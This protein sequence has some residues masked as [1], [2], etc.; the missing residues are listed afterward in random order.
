MQPTSSA[1]AAEGP[2]DGH[3]EPLEAL[4]RRYGLQPPAESRLAVLLSLLSTDTL[5]PTAVRD[6]AQAVD[7]HLAD[8]LVALELPEVRTARTIA[9]LGAGAGIPGLPLAIALPGAD[10]SLVESNARKA[11]FITRAV[12]ACGLANAHV[13]HSR[14]E[15]WTA[16]LDHFELVTARA[17][18]PPAVVA[19]YAAP[20]LRIGGALL[21]WRGQRDAEAEAAGARAAEQLGL[22]ASDPVAVDPFHGAQHRTLQLM[23]KVM[24]TPAG[25]PRREGM[26]RKRPLGGASAAPGTGLA[27][28]P[29]PSS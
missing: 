8:A 5:A 13:V 11:A 29:R 22:L 1:S 6:P 4:V 25:F 10:V 20:L 12:S 2:P 23:W 9:D 7:T 18:A 17:L 26:A 16:G 15:S 19:E 27:R 14:A 21:L 28:G 3:A 24:A